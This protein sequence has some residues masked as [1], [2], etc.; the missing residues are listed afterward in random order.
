MSLYQ[1]NLSNDNTQRESIQLDKTTMGY[2]MVDFEGHINIIYVTYRNPYENGNVLLHW[3]V[4]YR[5]SLCE[6]VTSLDTIGAYY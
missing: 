5:V 2:K 3:Y 6:F 4:Q 1:E